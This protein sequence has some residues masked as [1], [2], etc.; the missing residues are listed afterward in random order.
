M[1]KCE[2]CEEGYCTYYKSVEEQLVAETQ[3]ECDG[4]E[5]EMIE[6]GMIEVN[7]MKEY[8]VMFCINLPYDVEA[9][10]EESAIDKAF[11]EFRQ[12]MN[13]HLHYDEIHVEC[14]S[15]DDEDDDDDD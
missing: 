12:E 14:L 13:P 9:E 7:K 15:E 3:W 10:D 2:W 6:C 5:D 8:R 11:K 4:T 1:K